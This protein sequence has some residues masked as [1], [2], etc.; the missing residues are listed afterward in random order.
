[1][2]INLYE[3]T[4]WKEVEINNGKEKIPT[5]WDYK[6]L[7]SLGF[8]GRGKSKHRPRNDPK[9]FGD[10]YPFIQTAEVKEAKLWLTNKPEKYYS[11]FGLKQSKLW[12]E[13]TLCITI[14]A[15][16]AESSILTYKACFPD[17]V[18]GFIANK[19]T[20]TIF[21][22]Y[23]IDIL[24]K[25]MQNSAKG[26]AQDNLNLDKINL[27]KLP[28]PELSE[29]EHIVFVLL[30]QEKIISKTKN[31]IL[32]LN[33]RNKFLTDELLSG[34]LRVK[35]EGGQIVVYKNVDINWQSVNVNGEDIEI[36]KD[37][38]SFKLKGNIEIKTG[39]KDA[40]VAKN[41][42]KYAFFTCGKQVLKTNTY[43]FDCEAVLIAGNGDVGDTKYY[44]GKF[45][46][47]QRTYVLSNYK[48]DLKFLYI[49]M[50][51]LFQDS[52]NALG[53]AMPYIKLGDLE[54]FS[55]NQPQNIIERQLL[56]K[57]ITSLNEEKE[58]YEQILE[59]EEK[60]FTFLLEELMSGR[61]RVKV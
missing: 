39:K 53:S 59:Q 27:F 60:K 29:Q 22:K 5:S 55:V 21:V 56:L 7:D 11:D 54:N 25:K 58:K 37:W 3:N 50:K 20:N 38:D 15:N 12:D 2:I 49:Y 28:L 48:Y 46:A 9:L 61:L 17:S 41:D 4:D 24:K 44:Q 34:K 36:P 47:Y 14:A 6:N 8:L 19:D 40:N 51:K 57:I 13:G 52:I 18:L 26:S 33:K 16:I 32:E 45:D 30:S 35:E 42:G 43:D 10:K 23:Q 1:M 31:L